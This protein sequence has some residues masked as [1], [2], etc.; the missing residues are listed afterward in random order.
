MG[1]GGGGMRREGRVEGRRDTSGNGILCW[2]QGGT[3]CGL[4]RSGQTGVSLS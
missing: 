2:A 4:L 3:L 1:R